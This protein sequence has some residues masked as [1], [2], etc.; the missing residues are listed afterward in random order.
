[1]RIL[2]VEDDVELARWL[3]KALRDDRFTVDCAT[4][5]LTAEALLKVED[6]A[7][8]I[9]DLTLPRLDGLQVLKRFRSRGSRTPVL[10]LTARAEISERVEGLN[11]GADDYLLKPFALAEME[12]RI[13]ALL[14]RSQGRAE[15][16][17]T[18]GRLVF[19]T[20]NGVFLSA[21]AP[22]M[23]TPRE[24]AV[25]ESLITRAGKVV[26]K[27]KLFEQVFSLDDHSSPDAIEVYVHR[28]RR[29]LEGSGV[30]ITTF[31]GLGYLLEARDG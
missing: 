6:Y 28:V 9:L 25:L 13:K 20:I 10:I 24:H 18:C 19:D 14:R 16:R 7:L 21:G 11:L 17:I 3:A 26:R 31:R 5:G 30:V 1:M 2:L 4:D 15:S 23:L 12:A 29:K 22:L 8:V 27:E